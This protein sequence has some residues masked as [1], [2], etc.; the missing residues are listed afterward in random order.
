MELFSYFGKNTTYTL[1]KAPRKMSTEAENDR[2][3]EELNLYRK[4]DRKKRG[5]W[6]V[7]S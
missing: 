3:T 5:R 7:V 6:H 4:A 1:R 2:L